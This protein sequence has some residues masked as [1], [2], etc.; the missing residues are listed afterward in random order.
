MMWSKV[1]LLLV[2]YDEISGSEN[3]QLSDDMH[4]F[5]DRYSRQ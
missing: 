5:N 2:V 4:N 3:A 1:S